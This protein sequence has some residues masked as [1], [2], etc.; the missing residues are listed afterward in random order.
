MAMKTMVVEEITGTD[1]GRDA[2][3]QVFI[4]QADRYIRNYL[5]Q[6]VHDAEDTG[7]LKLH[8]QIFSGSN[9][10]SFYPKE[11]PILPLCLFLFFL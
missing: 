6:N 8:I 11:A 4:D 1:A 10:R 9:G 2:K 7:R 5:D 3:L